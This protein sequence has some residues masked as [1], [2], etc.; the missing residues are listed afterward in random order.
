[1]KYINNEYIVLTHN[2]NIQPEHILN[3]NTLS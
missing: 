1:M 3:L 2:V